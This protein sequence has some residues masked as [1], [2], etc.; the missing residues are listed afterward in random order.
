VVEVAASRIERLA[1]AVAQVAGRDN[2]ERADRRERAALGAAQHVSVVALVD[3]N[4]FN[5]AR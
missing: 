5:S 2:A 3:S 4:A 1:L